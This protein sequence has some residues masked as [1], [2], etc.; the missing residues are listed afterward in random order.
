MSKI[1]TKTL[2]HTMFPVRVCTRHRNCLLKVLH[3]IATIRRAK[4]RWLTIMKRD[5]HTFEL[6]LGEQAPYF[7]LPATDGKIYSL[8]D[9]SAVQALVVVFTCNHCPYSR[10]YETRLADIARRYQPMGVGMVGICANDADDFPEDSFERM[11]EKSELLGFPFPYLHD[12]KQHVARGYDAVCTPEAY[13]F[14]RKKTLIYHGMVDD[15]AEHPEEAKE[16]YLINAIE[17]ALAGET[18]K[19][20]QTAVIGCSIK[21]KN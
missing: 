14:D 4:C 7:S 21:W 11:V 1:P 2:E 20:Q 13:V 3:S 12:E 8:A 5:V 18:P 6:N 16:R 9:F 17:A 10:S 15:N 19:I